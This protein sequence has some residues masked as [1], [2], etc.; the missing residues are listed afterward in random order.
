[1]EIVHYFFWFLVFFGDP[2]S[3]GLKKDAAK[4]LGMAIAMQK[5]VAELDR[6]W[7]EDRGINAVSYTHLTLPTKA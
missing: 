6:K 7:R 5:K 3:A 1:M 4:C 2:E